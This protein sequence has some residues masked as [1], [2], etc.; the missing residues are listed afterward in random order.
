MK[1]SLTCVRMKNRLHIKG[2][3]FNLVLIQ[4]LGGNSEMAYCLMIWSLL[5]WCIKD[6]SRLQFSSQY[7]F[8]S[9]TSE[10]FM[11]L[12]RQFLSTH[13]SCPPHTLE[14]KFLIYKLYFYSHCNFENIHYQCQS[15]KVVM[16]FN[17]LA[18][19]AENARMACLLPVH[20]SSWAFA[21]MMK[22][23]PRYWL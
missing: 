3:A 4:R 12:L 15:S 18:R 13:F 14:I 6:Q 10:H 1:I 19:E 17:I 20:W 11:M 5:Y 8:D 21:R 9:L 7:S 16:W 2:W 22:T 23:E